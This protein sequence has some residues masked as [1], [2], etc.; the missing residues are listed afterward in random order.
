MPQPG[1]VVL[2][3]RLE[4]I[5]KGRVQGVGFRWYTLQQAQR[6]GVR[7]TVRNL[8]DGSVHI[9]A[10][11][12]REELEH[13]LHWASSGPPHA[14]VHTTDVRWAEA[15]GEFVDFLITG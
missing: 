3:E 9:V 11:G 14:I 2:T 13:L 1:K 15:Q 7:G 4:V 6:C 10:E 8:S 12:D 5:L